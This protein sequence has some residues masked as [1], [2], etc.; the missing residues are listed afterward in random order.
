MLYLVTGY[1]KKEEYMSD[2]SKEKK[3]VTRLVDADSVAEAEVKFDNSYRAK[4]DEYAIY[5][6]TEQV[7]ATE[8]II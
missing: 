2:F 1:I 5:Y 8:T 4:S 3:F 6:S 7:T